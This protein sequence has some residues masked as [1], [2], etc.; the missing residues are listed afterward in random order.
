MTGAY[1][2]QQ[3]A[4]QIY[5]KLQRTPNEKFA[6]VLYDDDAIRTTPSEGAAFKVAMQIATLIGVYD[7]R[8]PLDWIE[9]DIKA[10]VGPKWLQY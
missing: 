10:V 2:P 9:E 7:H 3:R 4:R 6:V 5:D 8:S 1:G